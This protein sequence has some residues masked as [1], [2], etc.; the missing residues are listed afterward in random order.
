MPSDLEAADQ[1]FITSTTRNLLP[2][3]EAGDAP[4]RQ[5]PGV[6]AALNSAFERYQADYAAFHAPAK[7]TSP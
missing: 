3:L 2:V 1:V 6:L 7:A 5:S 4:L